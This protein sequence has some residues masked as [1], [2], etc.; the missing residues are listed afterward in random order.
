M[1]Q[2]EPALERPDD[3]LDA[4]PRPAGETL[5]GRLS[6]RRA[7][8]TIG[9]N[10]QRVLTIDHGGHMISSTKIPRREL[11]MRMTGNRV[12]SIAAAAFTVVVAP[13][14]L[15]IPSA[16]ASEG[17]AGIMAGCTNWTPHMRG[18]IS[19]TAPVHSS[20]SGSSRVI[21]TWKYGQLFRVDKRCVNSAG[22][23][24]WHSDCCTGIQ[25]Y[26]WNDYTKVTGT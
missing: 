21:A 2:A 23:L 8:Q 18:V 26:I 25:G 11:E 1:F 14:V 15:V 9:M 7:G 4:L 19:G 24:W 13:A 20:Y 22:N 16:A 5:P 17:G 10:L 12:L 6:S 3:R